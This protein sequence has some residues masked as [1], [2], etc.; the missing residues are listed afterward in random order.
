MDF[1]ND[2]WAGI[3]F[4]VLVTLILSVALTVIAFRMI[5]FLQARTAARVA[6]SAERD[7]RDLA[8]QSVQ[9]QDELIAELN[10]L[11]R[12]ETRLGEVERM[13]R[14]VDEPALAR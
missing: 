1:S 9:R 6:A 14:E 4:T 10:R 3:I 8:Q 7:Y 12:I 13:L 2:P 5:G 11:E